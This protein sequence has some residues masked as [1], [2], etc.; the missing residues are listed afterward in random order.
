MPARVPVIS[1][2][3]SCPSETCMPSIWHHTHKPSTQHPSL[4]PQLERC[5][6]AAGLAFSPPFPKQEPACSI[7]DTQPVI[8]QDARGV[9][10]SSQ[11]SVH[12][13]RAVLIA[14]CFDMTFISLHRL[15]SNA[16]T[17]I[18][19]L[20]RPL[21]EQERKLMQKDHFKNYLFPW[22]TSLSWGSHNSIWPLII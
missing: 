1:Y 13:S 21:A 4:G 11:D 9:R 10:D 14:V 16:N 12:S 7:T 19:V 6:Q 3:T 15:M 17:T 2:S 18:T 20:C 5:S 8:S 22:P